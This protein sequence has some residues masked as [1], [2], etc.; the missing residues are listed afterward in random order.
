M[1]GNSFRAGNAHSPCLQSERGRLLLV[2]I[3]KEKLQI[4]SDSLRGFRGSKRWF[5]C[6][7]YIQRD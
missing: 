5:D 6:R 4:K 3:K 7:S 2:R 1:S